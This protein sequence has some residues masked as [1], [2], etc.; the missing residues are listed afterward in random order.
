MWI[1]FMRRPVF[2]WRGR[3]YERWRGELPGVASYDNPRG[4]IGTILKPLR[5]G[6]VPKPI[7][8]GSDFWHLVHVR[9]NHA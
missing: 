9:A 8:G 2:V 1:S 5:T 3:T 4:T 6:R 7:S